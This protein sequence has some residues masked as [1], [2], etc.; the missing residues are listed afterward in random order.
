MTSIHDRECLSG[1]SFPKAEAKV[2]EGLSGR[3]TDLK[4]ML[5]GLS[6]DID[7]LAAVL[8]FVLTVD[9]TSE[10]NKAPTSVERGETPAM[11]QVAG[12]LT[13]VGDLRNRV[14]YLMRR[15]RL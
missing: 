13:F 6:K 14:A 4:M 2:E 11:E 3:L 12:M 15:V 1:S 7:D 9:E 10:T 5:G 8:S